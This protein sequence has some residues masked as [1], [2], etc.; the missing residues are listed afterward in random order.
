M[1]R[2]KI[3]MFAFAAFFKALAEPKRV[4]A[5]QVQQGKEGCNK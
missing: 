3:K 2:R 4:E 5:W 1:L